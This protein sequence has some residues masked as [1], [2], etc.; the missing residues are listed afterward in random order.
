MDTALIEAAIRKAIA[1]GASPRPRCIRPQSPPHDIDVVRARTSVG[2]TPEDL[3]A[4]VQSCGA[5]LTWNASTTCSR[6]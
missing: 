3:S 2:M 4:Y 1:A 6:Q 5:I